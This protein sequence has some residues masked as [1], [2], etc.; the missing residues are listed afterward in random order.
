MA[1]RRTIKQAPRDV[2]EALHTFPG[3]VPLGIANV[4]E[5]KHDRWCPWV[6]DHRLPS[7]CTLDRAR[8]FE[9]RER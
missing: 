7:P 5:V 1:N 8:A 6:Q 2:A 9:E 3:L 4:L